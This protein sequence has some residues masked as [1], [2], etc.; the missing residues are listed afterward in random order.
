MA[1]VFSPSMLGPWRDPS[2]RTLIAF[3][4]AGCIWNNLPA[5]C[6]F[7]LLSLQMPGLPNKI[8][9]VSAQGTR[10]RLFTWTNCGDVTVTVQNFRFTIIRNI[11]PHITHMVIH[12]PPTQSHD[13]NRRSLRKKR[14]NVSRSVVALLQLYDSTNVGLEGVS[15]FVTSDP[16]ILLQAAGN[17]DAICETEQPTDAGRCHAGKHWNTWPIDNAWLSNYVFIGI[18]MAKC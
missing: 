18:P 10:L 13:C 2:S 3:F 14:Q 12:Y 5:S 4:S 16:D 17:L 7:C 15:V 11:W 9:M 1:Q 6:V 8:K